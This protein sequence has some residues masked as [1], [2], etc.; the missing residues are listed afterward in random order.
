VSNWL[1]FF[2]PACGLVFVVSGTFMLFVAVALARTR[3]S[4]S[5]TVPSEIVPSE[6]EVAAKMQKLRSDLALRSGL[7]W[8]RR[9][10][11]ASGPFWL[12]VGLATLWFS[13][14]KAPWILPIVGLSWTCF[15]AWAT[16][17]TFRRRGR[18]TDDTADDEVVSAIVADPMTPRS[19]RRIMLQQG[20]WGMLFLCLGIPLFWLSAP[21]IGA[22]PLVVPP[23]ENDDSD[24]ASIVRELVERDFARQGHVGMM[25][26]VV[27]G[28]EEVLLGFGARGLGN[29]NPPDADT[30]FEI[31]SIT[32]VFT[33]ILLAQQIEKGELEL[34]D[35]V[36][37]LLPEGWELSE[38]ARE[39]T[40]RHCTTHASGLP[41]LPENHMSFSRAIRSLFRGD[42]YRDYSEQAFRDAL[43]TTQVEFEPGTRSLYSNFA[44]GLLGFVL[45]TH[46]KTDYEALVTSQ[47]CRPLGMHDTFITQ[48]PPSL[49]HGLAGYRT[50]LRL[51]P[52]MM[53]LTS[54]DWRLPNHLAGAGGIRSTGRDMLTFLKAN[55]G[56]L[57]TPL[58]PAME[59]SHQ[60][61]H[62]AEMR[63]GM[64]WIHS[65]TSGLSGPVI[66]HNGGTGGF[67]TYLGFTEDQELGVFVLSNTSSDVNTLAVEI[68]EALGKSPRR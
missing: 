32:K 58:D 53:A 33:G 4:D 34:D 39:I 38:A 23:A 30:P 8:T 7:T 25:V 13:E 65:F 14:L 9:I 68:L 59:R 29:R 67:S 2:L 49:E 56:R 64:N 28:N 54:D 31:G 40:L 36:A 35:R 51:G 44:M 18:Q 26:G 57:S 37:D 66:W 19:K 24:L 15:G 47:I 21:R 48:A 62:R 16:V 42:P 41:R 63:I 1:Y 60:E 17:A 6:I 52:A 20:V 61:L 5:A 45:A 22:T 50:T 43:A 55:M 10:D 12:L 46:G 11:Q 3:I 27:L